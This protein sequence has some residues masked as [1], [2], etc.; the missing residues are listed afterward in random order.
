MFVP[1]KSLYV[2]LIFTGLR[3][4]STLSLAPIRHDEVAMVR[5]GTGATAH[6]CSFA[7]RRSTRQ[8]LDRVDR[9]QRRYYLRLVSRLLDEQLFVDC[10]EL[11][12]QALLRG[13]VNGLI[14][15]LSTAEVL[16]AGGRLAFASGADGGPL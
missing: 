1:T 8:L 2:G 9:S 15:N 6:Q 10:V 3:T 12:L 4:H 5:R 7:N 11:L 16:L 13:F 14:G